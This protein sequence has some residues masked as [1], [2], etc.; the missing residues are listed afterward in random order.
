MRWARAFRRQSKTCLCLA[1]AV[2][3]AGT[4]LAEELSPAMTFGLPSD[5]TAVAWSP[6][7]KTIAASYRWGS[8]V[9]IL[10]ADNDTQDPVADLA[11]S[12]LGYGIIKTFENHGSGYI[13]PSLSFQGNSHTLITH[14]SANDY[15]LREFDTSTGN[16]F[17]VPS[18]AKMD[19]TVARRPDDFSVSS[20]GSRVAIIY[21]LMTGMPVIVYD[22]S[23]WA[24]KQLI[25][26][27]RVHSGFDPPTAVSV[28]ADGGLLV[29][30]TL[31]G[32]AYLYD[33]NTGGLVRSFDVCKA[34]NGLESIALSPDGRYMALGRNGGEVPPGNELTAPGV[35]IVDTATGNVSASHA[36]GIIGILQLAWSPDGGRLAF[37]TADDQVYVV[38]SPG[39]KSYSAT[40]NAK[41][42]LSVAWSPD[43]AAIA[44]AAGDYV[45]VY[46]LHE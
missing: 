25:D 27:R 39:N 34:T 31:K 26:I 16:G 7:G 8:R 3:G 38:S 24:V 44:V 45:K 12:Y 15:T 17:E 30:G 14:S 41:L 28:S 35:C 22:T 46:K 43:S 10:S 6:D 1:L 2:A 40:I 19:G 42:A 33:L 5:V 21:G 18:P 9:A 13:G 4:S 32:N 29:V 36:N 11:R 37:A 23:D 20:D